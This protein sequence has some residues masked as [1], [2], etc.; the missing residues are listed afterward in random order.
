[1]P[2]TVFCILTRLEA[3]GASPPSTQENMEVSRLGTPPVHTCMS[4]AKSL[5]EQTRTTCRQVCS[6]ST[7]KRYRQCWDRLSLGEAETESTASRTP[8]WWSP[9]LRC[10]I[11]TKHTEG[12]TQAQFP[13]R[14][15]QTQMMRDLYKAGRVLHGYTG[16]EMTSKLSLSL[17]WKWLTDM[18]HK[19][20][21]TKG[22]GGGEG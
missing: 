8:P 22:E 11:K 19:V 21:L 16:E 13:T 1:M 17:E 4:S 2:R 9:F 7:M 3:N 20:M 15:A 12:L 10:C 14:L 6:S 5:S 18:E